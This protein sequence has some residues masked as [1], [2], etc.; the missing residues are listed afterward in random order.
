MPSPENRGL[1]R[2]ISL[3]PDINTKEQSLQEKEL[4]AKLVTFSGDYANA[5]IK[6]ELGQMAKMGGG[7]EAI[8]PVPQ[9]PDD[10]KIRLD[11]FA[12]KLFKQ[13]ALEHGLKL[14]V[15]TEDG[16]S[17][18]GVDKEK[19]VEATA[20]VDPTDNSGEHEAGLDTPPYSAFTFFDKNLKPRV[21]GICDF[22]RERFL[23]YLEG[24]NRLFQYV[25]VKDQEGR[26]IGWDVEE[27]E[28]K[29][30]S[31][32]KITDPGFVLMAYMGSNLYSLPFIEN[33]GLNLLRKMHPK[34]RFHGKGGSH[35]PLLLATGADAYVMVDDIRTEV[36]PSFVMAKAGGF[37]VWVYDQ[38]RKV[39]EYEFDP[40][41]ED[42]EP[43]LHRLIMAR[44]E[45][46]RDA[47]ADIF[48]SDTPSPPGRG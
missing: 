34:G 44:N 4:I 10:T 13:K 33:G 12:D 7:R 39:T 11:D 42:N 21:G 20:A 37:G 29:Q 22:L 28:I 36:S 31:V 2:F 43:R 3:N 17:L 26:L 41:I 8:G 16:K 45:T 18:I 27:R 15:I 9:R 47:V 46:I 24:Q 14:L 40:S 48:F 38:N 19:D 32:K 30:A 35:A 23:F 6:G 5:A 25:D 1:E